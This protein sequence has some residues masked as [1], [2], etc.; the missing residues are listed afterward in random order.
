MTKQQTRI[1]PVL[2][3]LNKSINKLYVGPLIESNARPT[4]VQ[5]KREAKLSTVIG[6]ITKHADCRITFI[7]YP[8]RY[9]SEVIRKISPTNIFSQVIDQVTIK[10]WFP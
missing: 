9:F 2:T 5:L 8:I 1:S 3:N 7:L 10:F 4:G 6:L